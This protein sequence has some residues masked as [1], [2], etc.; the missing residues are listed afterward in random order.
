MQKVDFV[1][2]YCTIIF[3]GNSFVGGWEVEVFC[4]ISNIVPATYHR[5]RS[6]SKADG[7]ID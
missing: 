2:I 3:R 6:S 4:A 5:S 7:R 1:N